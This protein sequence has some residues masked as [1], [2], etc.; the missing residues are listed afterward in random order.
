MPE[1]GHA[2]VRVEDVLSAKVRQGLFDL[3]H[4]NPHRAIPRLRQLIELFPDVPVLYNWLSVAYQSAKDYESM[5]QTSQLLYER[6][7]KY[8]FGRLDVARIALQAGDLRTSKRSWK[9]NST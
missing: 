2:G 4:K 6:H 9:R 8:L 5:T 3:V 7:P 1:P